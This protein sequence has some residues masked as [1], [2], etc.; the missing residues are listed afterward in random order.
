MVLLLRQR[1]SNGFCTS[2]DSKIYSSV[3][4]LN[5]MSSE[6][7]I[8]TSTA[9]P[10]VLLSQLGHYFEPVKIDLDVVNS[11]RLFYLRINILYLI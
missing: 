6:L 11:P 5:K 4:R 2:I 1:K 8:N 10:R 7:E 9:L 3:A